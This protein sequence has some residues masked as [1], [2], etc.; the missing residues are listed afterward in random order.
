M[1]Y[2][3]V[4]AWL[5]YHFNLWIICKSRY[6]RFCYVKCNWNLQLQVVKTV[7]TLL[8]LL[9]RNIIFIVIS[10]INLYLQVSVAKRAQNYIRKP[11]VNNR[12][13]PFHSLYLNYV[14]TYYSV[15]GL[16]LSICLIM[17][18]CETYEIVMNDPCLLYTSRCV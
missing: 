8:C 4:A 18:C 16:Y 12:L 6:K 11:M 10:F 5:M 7:N 1:F 9:P 15:I 2:P 17:P 13:Y 14:Y 3:N